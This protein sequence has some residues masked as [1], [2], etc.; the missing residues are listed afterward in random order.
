MGFVFFVV[1]CRSRRARPIS[2]LDN[3]IM[4][5][6]RHHNGNIPE[7][8][9]ENANP[10]GVGPSLVTANIGTDVHMTDRTRSADGT[11]DGTR[12][13]PATVGG[14]VIIAACVLLAYYPCM[15]GGFILDDCVLLTDN[16]IVKAARR[17]AAILVHHPSVRILSGYEFLVLD[18]VADLGDE[19]GRIPGGKPGDAHNRRAFDLVYFAEIVDSRGFFG[20]AAVCRASG[21]RGIGGLDM[22]NCETCW[23]SVSFCCRFW[24]TFSRKRSRRRGNAKG[25]VPFSL[26]RKSGQS[27][28]NTKLAVP[29]SLTRKSGQS[30]RNTKL[31]V[32]FSLTRKSGQSPGR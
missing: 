25:T 5:N 1:K 28:R 2:T 15:R 24:L 26:T 21:E 11:L 23:R 12:S 19:P 14:A 29:F 3:T 22:R 30:P 17:A 18:R 20:G 13:V 10:Q 27:P 7:D 31:A 8:R 9:L 4:P 6:M 32:P 16:Y